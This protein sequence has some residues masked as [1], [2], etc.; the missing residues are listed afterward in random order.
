V[1]AIRDGQRNEYQKPDAGWG[2]CEL[3]HTQLDFYG[4][5]AGDIQ[6]DIRQIPGCFE[7][8]I[9]FLTGLGNGKSPSPRARAI[10]AGG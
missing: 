6:S 8:G 3:A 7:P 9:A 1:H 5:R 4:T 10:E 2:M